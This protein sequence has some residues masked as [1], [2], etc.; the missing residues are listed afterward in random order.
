MTKYF[1]MAGVNGVVLVEI[2]LEFYLFFWNLMDST[3]KQKNDRLNQKK[4]R[5]N[6]ISTAHIFSILYVQY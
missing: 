3:L 6:M 1:I 5:I 2:T 4:K